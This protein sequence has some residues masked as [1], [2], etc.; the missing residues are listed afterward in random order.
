MDLIV[1]IILFITGII[2][3]ISEISRLISLTFRLF[4]NM[5]A[6][7]ILLVSIMFMVPY[8]VPTV[9]YGLEVLV[10]FIQALV[11]ASLAIVYISLGYGTEAE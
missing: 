10:G 4:G 7:E 8:L 6:G 3:L 1:G 9:F 11:F 2:E 5:T